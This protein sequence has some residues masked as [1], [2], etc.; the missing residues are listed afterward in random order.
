MFKAKDCMTQNVITVPLG[1]T[2]YEAIK[3]LVY[4][5]ITGLPVISPD[6]SLVGMLSEK[7]MLKLLYEEDNKELQVDA[8]M[9]PDVISFNEDES[10]VDI[11]EALIKYTFRRVP[12]LADGKLVGIISRGDVMKYILKLKYHEKL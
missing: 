8:V 2:C 3:I 12:I 5:K 11:C 4:N 7:D 10:L 6:G 1:S 9:T